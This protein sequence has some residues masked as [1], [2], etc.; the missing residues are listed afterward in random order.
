[1]LAENFVFEK[2]YDRFVYQKYLI[3]VYM[4]VGPDD[5]AVQNDVVVDQTSPDDDLLLSKRELNDPELLERGAAFT[6]KYLNVTEMLRM[7]RVMIN[8]SSLKRRFDFMFPGCAKDWIDGLMWASENFG[9][10]FPAVCEAS[11]RHDE[12]LRVADERA[13]LAAENSKIRSSVEQR[14]SLVNDVMREIRAKMHPSDERMV[15]AVFAAIGFD[16]ES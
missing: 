10:I 9:R 14:R 3:Q 4:T 15:D 16:P 5:L 8:T 2:E 12:G 6:A 7:G 11:R 1:M 13:R